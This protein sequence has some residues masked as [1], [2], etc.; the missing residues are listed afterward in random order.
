MTSMEVGR[1]SSSTRS[2]TIGVQI[3]ATLSPC[4]VIR[5]TTSPRFTLARRF[6]LRSP[7]FPTSK[8][9]PPTRWTRATGEADLR[10]SATLKRRDEP[11]Q[12]LCQARAKEKKGQ[13]KKEGEE[14]VKSK[15]RVAQIE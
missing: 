9:S 10:S 12:Y 5:E 11:R 13:R 3:G 7:A 15:G 4:R 1:S 6:S 14:G 2:S 8:R